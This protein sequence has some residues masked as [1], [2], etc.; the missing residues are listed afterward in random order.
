[1]TQYYTHKNQEGGSLNSLVT[2]RVA[3]AQNRLNAN[4]VHTLKRHSDISLTE[5]RII[6]LLDMYDGASLSDL[7]KE[8]DMDKG[9]LSRK[10]NAMIDKG[11]LSTQTDD[12]DHRIQHLHLTSEARKIHQDVRPM[13][14]QRQQELLASI[15]Q[16]ELEVFLNVLDKIEM[17]AT[18]K[19]PSQR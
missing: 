11:W 13:M 19:E 4:A 12:A 8:V 16:N 14:E 17:A 9:Q 1:M 18:V 15:E 10:T 3:R 5:W 6:H 2:Y 7:A